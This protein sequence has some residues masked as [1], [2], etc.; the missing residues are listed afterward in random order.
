MFL[1]LLIYHFFTFSL[2]KRFS[3][4]LYKI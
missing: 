2:C 3:L 4:N 1:S